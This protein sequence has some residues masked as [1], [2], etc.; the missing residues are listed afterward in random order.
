MGFFSWK[1][2]GCGESIKAPYDIPKELEWH[3]KIV[4]IIPDGTMLGGDYDGYGRVI[5]DEIVNSTPFQLP[6]WGTPQ[7]DVWHDK[8]HE[9]AGSPTAYTGGSESAPDQGFFYA[10]EGDTDDLR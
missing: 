8:C 2:E 10:K 5:T 3:N 6:T 9:E 7:A 4:V 1:C